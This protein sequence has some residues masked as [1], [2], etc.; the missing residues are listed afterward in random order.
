MKETAEEYGHRT[1]K[2]ALEA[3][4]NLDLHDANLELLEKNVVVE[5]KESEVDLFD[6]MVN[7]V[8]TSIDGIPRETKKRVLAPKPKTAAEEIDELFNKAK[9]R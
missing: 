6:K 4:E 9:G 7:D 3:K 8:Y 5:K 2:M 1:L